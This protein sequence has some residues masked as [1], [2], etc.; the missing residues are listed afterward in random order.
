MNI[1]CLVEYDGS[2]FYGFQKQNDVRTI[3]VELENALS[4]FTNQE[5]SVICAGRTDTG[6]HATGQVINFN[7][8]VIRPLGAYTRGV[9]ALLPKDITILKAV[10]VAD[11]FHARFSAVSRTYVYYLYNCPTRP[12]ILN[13]KVGWY[14]G[15]LNL[16]S[17]QEACSLLIGEHDFS[18]FRASQCQANNPVKLMH[19]C[20]LEISQLNPKIL[21]FR[22][23]ANSF[24]HH[25]I[26]NIVG[27]MIY[28]GNGKLSINDFKKLIAQRNRVYAPPTFMADGLYLTQVNYLDGVLDFN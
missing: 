18:S 15:E 21:C 22:F 3:Q 23:C 17:I 26:R 1:A 10:T 25:M 8:S 12:A 19:Q 2:S 13:S 16:S 24:L 20:E 11:D 14:H 6:V 5:I 27:S 4:Q 28:I 7:T 9:N